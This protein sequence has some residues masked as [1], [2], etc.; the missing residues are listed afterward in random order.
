ME[1]DEWQF[2]HRKDHRVPKGRKDLRVHK[3]RKRHKD[4]KGRR[5][6]KDTQ[7]IPTLAPR[8]LLPVMEHSGFGM[9]PQ[10]DPYNTKQAMAAAPNASGKHLKRWVHTRVPLRYWPKLWD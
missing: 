3:D 10:P 9:E 6:H 5:G 4:R 1:F 8:L 2:L 7:E